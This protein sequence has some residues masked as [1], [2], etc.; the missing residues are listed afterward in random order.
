MKRVYLV[1]LPER[2]IHGVNAACFLGLVATGF[3]IRFGPDFPVL[4]SMER[5]VRLHNALGVAF[6]ISFAAWI[7]YAFVTRRVRYFLPSGVDRRDAVYRQARYYVS[8]IFTGADYPFA[9]SEQ[10]KFNPFQKTTYLIL[11]FALVPVQVVTGVYLLL[12]IRRWTEFDS[13]ALIG[14]S[15]AHVAAAFAG[16]AFLLSHV[17]MATTG[18]RPLSSF[19][20]I[21]TGYHKTDGE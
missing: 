14:W 5:A 18:P 3:E 19:R 10:N 21:I 17:Y 8:G 16:A 11:M 4:D 2:V 1:T 7:A 13:G 12:A 9:P 6:A 20:T 15:F